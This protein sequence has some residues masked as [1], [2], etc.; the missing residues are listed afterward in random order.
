LDGGVVDLDADFRV[1]VGVK[2]K[3]KYYQDDKFI[4]VMF[5]I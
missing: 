1:G 4:G 3:K 2:E 5:H